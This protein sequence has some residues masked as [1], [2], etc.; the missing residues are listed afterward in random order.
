[1]NEPSPNVAVWM[2]HPD[3]ARAPR[4]TLPAKYT[5]RFFHDGDVDT[6]VRIQQAAEPFLV[7]TADTF[8]RAMPG[9]PA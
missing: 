3:L 8:T 5:M 1:M 9:D 6:W 2:L 4:H 7:P